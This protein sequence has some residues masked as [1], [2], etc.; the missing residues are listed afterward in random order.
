MTTIGARIRSVITNLIDERLASEDAQRSADDLLQAVINARDPLDGSA[1]SRR[2]IIDEIAVL[3]LAGHETSASALTWSLFILSQQP[4]IA[5]EIR[6]LALDQSGGLPL[7]QEGVNKIAVAREVFRESLRL[8]PPGGFLARVAHEAVT[9][10]GYE[11]DAGTVIVISPWLIHRHFKYWKEPDLFDPGR[12]STA[13]ER[14]IISGTYLPF[15]I[16]SRACTG[17]TVAMIEGPLI[18]AETVQTLHLEPVHP[19]T[20][21]PSFHL[22]IRPDKPIR[23]RVYPL[24]V[25][26]ENFSRV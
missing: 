26:T 15:G 8:Y 24:P 23:C 19:E 16:G 10:S 25:C 1:F 4:Q 12:F 17:R 22:T 7:T 21:L 9:I 20:V 2:E 13:R 18:I 14:E 11:V 6:S 5:D 3:F